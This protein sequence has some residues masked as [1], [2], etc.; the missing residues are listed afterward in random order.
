MVLSDPVRVI[1]GIGPKKAS[2]CQRLSINTLQDALECYPRDYED[3]TH[4]QP[5]ATVQEGKNACVCAVVGTQPVTRHIR[6]GMEITR[7]RIFDT[8]GTLMVTYYNN[9]YTANALKEGQEYVFYGRIQGSG[10]W[11]SI[12]SPDYE[13]VTPHLPPPQRIVP[14]YPL[15]AGL[16]QKDLYRITS[17]ALDALH[18]QMD[19]M[20]SEICAR[21]RLLSQAEAIR[22]IHRPETLEQV[23]QARRRIIFEELFL[24]CCGLSYLRRRRKDEQGICLKRGFPSAFWVLLPFE[25][26]TAQRR[27]AEDIWHDVQSG[28]P[29]NRL[30]Q[31]DVG[32]G[33]TMIAAVLCFLAAVNGYQSAIMAPTE[34]L[35]AQHMESLSP[36]FAQ[37]GI[38]CALLSGSMTAKQKRECKE[39]IAAG[40]IQIV[41]GT[42]AVIQKDVEF[43]RLGAVVVDEQHRFGVAQRAA[44]NEKGER[45]H[46]LVM[47]AT[48]IPRT[49]ALILYGD[50]DVSVVDELPPGRMPVETFAVGENLRLRIYAFMEKR[51]QEGGQVYVVC[52]LVTEGGLPLK[53]AQEHA[54]QLRKML[55][56]CRIGVVYGK[57][58]AAD[59]E[60]VMQDFAA[61]RL[62]ILVTTTVIEVG[63][64]VPNACLMVIEDADRFGLSQLHQLRGRVGRGSRR[65]YCICFGADKGL[66]ARKRLKI[67][68]ETNDGF[69][70]ARADL[71]Q[72]GPGDFFGKRQHGL[73]ELKV[74]DLSANL[75]LMQEAK[76]EAERVLRQ[77]PEL[78]QHRALRERV[79]Q[80]FRENA[81]E[82]FN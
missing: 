26:T 10:K 78:L 70:I 34:I 4:I 72:R 43:Q 29:M 53:S 81:G 49:L 66:Q 40:E 57:M 25:P 56:R 68:C 2:L 59:K 67:L 39:K 80:M 15:T 31:G 27:A 18:T 16:T 35:A 73:P 20:P 13:P 33:K 19:W 3:R 77:D 17:A 22:L 46:M 14:L 76:R 48:P 41:I 55:P 42:H 24:L 62:D 63:V 45:P 79:A 65:S 37:K 11:R 36:I 23:E 12:V 71:A 32:S 64:N 47:S 8:S 21:H 5:I 1:K 82:I 54:A 38:T 50:L 74:A 61:G 51:I 58:K 9:P 75:M 69:E 44:L 60:S 28:K 30:V 6:K 7:F 52:P